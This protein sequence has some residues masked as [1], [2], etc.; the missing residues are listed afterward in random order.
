MAKI[1]TRLATDAEREACYRLAYDVFCTEMGTMQELADHTQ[2]LVHDE[3]IAR[4]HLVG[5]W[6]DGE[7]AGTLGMLVGGD[8]PFP[9]YFTQGFNVPGFLPVVPSAQM[10]INIRFA[11]KPSFRSSVVPF[12][13]MA[14]ATRWQVERGIRLAFCDC[15]PHLLPLYLGLGFRPCAPLFDQA[16]FG[17]MAPLTLSLSDVDYLRTIHSPLLRCLP[18]SIEDRALAARIRARLPVEPDVVS[19]TADGGDL[20]SAL[21]RLLC[22]ER[23]EASPLLGCT[24]AER[25]ALLGQSQLLA[26]HRDQQIL[27]QG[28]KTRSVYV[29]IAG[30]VEV[31]KGATRLALLTPGDLVGTLAI[32]QHG[33]WTADVYATSDRVRLLAF[34]A[35][36]WQ[37]LM[38]SHTALAT[39]FLDNV[40]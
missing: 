26:C 33:R 2:R 10:S 34:S 13:L 30:A 29:V 35:Q 16:G 31:R 8:G 6:V 37:R 7:L 28:Q 5:T 14:A 1:L 19:P 18:A 39:R 38:A 21:Y 3:A 4:A 40:S 15:Q 12:R 27:V 36:T 25:L 23:G 9:A 32:Q 11:V 22:Q 17:M 20:P 24:E